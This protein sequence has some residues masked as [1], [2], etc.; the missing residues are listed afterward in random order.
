MRHAAGPRRELGIRTVFNLLGPLT[1]P[2]AP[3]YQSLGIWERRLVPV[4]A[5]VLRELGAKGV[6]VFHGAGGLD[7]LS[8]SGENFVA[9]LRDGSIKEYALLPQDAGLE[10]APLSAIQGGLPEENAA[11]TLEIL[12]GQKGPRRDVVLFNAAALLKAAGVCDDWKEAVAMA[13]R[14]IDSGKAAQRL[15]ALRIAAREVRCG[16][17]SDGCGQEKAIGA[18]R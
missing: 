8:L 4:A 13:G 16:A 1:N 12:A 17:V 2:A 6:M 10:P 7:E 5:E 15:E 11:I 9:E 18:G 14:A 3:A